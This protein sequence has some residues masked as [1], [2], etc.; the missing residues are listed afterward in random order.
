MEYNH[1]DFFNFTS[2]SCLKFIRP[3]RTVF[4]ACT[5]EVGAVEPETPALLLQVCLLN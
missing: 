3:L 5:S 2:L 1:L 4:P